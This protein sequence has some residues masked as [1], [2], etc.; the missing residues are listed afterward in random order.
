MH[1][2]PS[3]VMNNGR[4]DCLQNYSDKFVILASSF[5]KVS[6]SILQALVT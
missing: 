3:K 4:A 1:Y 6:A 5:G 2:S